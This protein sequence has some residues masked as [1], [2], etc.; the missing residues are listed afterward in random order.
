M[1]LSCKRQQLPA[2]IS[3]FLQAVSLAIFMLLCFTLLC[4]V[5]FCF[6]L[7][8]CSP[9]LTHH[10]LTHLCCPIVIA[11]FELCYILC[12]HLMLLMQALRCLKLYLERLGV[13][14]QPDGS[15]STPQD[16]STAT[17]NLVSRAVMDAEFLNYRPT[18]TAAAVLYCQR[19]QQGLLP[20]WPSSLAGLTGYSN[21]R[22]PELAAA[23][24]GAQRLLKQLAGG[25][26]SEAA[27]AANTAGAASSAAAAGE[28][29]AAAAA[30]ADTGS[31]CYAADVEVAVSD[32]EDVTAKMAAASITE[33]GAAAAA[34]AA[35]SATVAVTAS[36][37]V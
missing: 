36:A 1:V 20:F 32:A 5:L 15:C 13:T 6:A 31:A 7:L 23:I 24:N 35:G 19:L 29:T 30:A 8:A 3:A 22:T 37:A 2:S 28:A 4:V 33:T 12:L 21:A 14:F 17:I 18:I 16:A 25:K 9:V 34:A 11:Q 27:S 10:D 26:V